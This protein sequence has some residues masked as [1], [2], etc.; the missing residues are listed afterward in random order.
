MKRNFL[1]ATSAAA[2]LFGL[3]VNPVDAAKAKAAGW[4]NWRG[5]HQ[6]GASDETN[7][8]DEIDLKTGK[9]NWKSG[10]IGDGYW[11]L[12]ANGNRI[13]ALSDSG[14][15]YHIAADPKEYRQLSRVRVSDGQ[16]WA[17]LAVDGDQILIRELDGLKALKWTASDEESEAGS[18][19]R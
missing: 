10:P 17:H 9:M 4:L 14:E 11:S 19:N 1:L 5:P 18:P 7:L 3:S 13:L 15:L 16:T 6:T 8:P 12:V 2:L